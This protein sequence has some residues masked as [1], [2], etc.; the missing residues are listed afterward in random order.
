MLTLVI[1]ITKVTIRMASASP[2]AQALIERWRSEEDMNE[3]DNLLK[4]MQ[5][6][7]IF[8][9]AHQDQWEA[10]GGV[11]PDISDPNFLPKLLRK[12]EFQESKQK[13]VKQSLETGE[14]KCRSSEDFQLSSV[15]RFVSRILSPRTPYNSF[16]LY[17]GVGVGKTCAAI[18]VCESYLEAYPGRKIYIIAPPNIQEGFRRTIFDKEGLTIPKKGRNSHRGCTGDIYL[19]LTN[20][21]D[22]KDEKVIES[23]VARL[24]KSRYEFF[25][26]T[27]FY[28]HIRRLLNKIPTNLPA[29]RLE[30]LKREI[31]RNE[32]SNRAIIID[33]A[34]N[35]RDILSSTS[36][37]R[38]SQEQ[39]QGQGQGQ[40]GQGQEGQEEGQE[41]DSIDDIS[42][43]DTAESK[44]GKRLTPYLKEV[45]QISEGITLLLMTA[46]P[47]YN[48]YTEIVFLLNLL[49]IN[50]KFPTLDIDDIFDQKRQAFNREKNG[51]KLLGKVASCYVSFMRGENPLTFPLRLDPLDEKITEWPHKYP[52]GKDISEEERGR[53]VK[54]P[55]VGAS[56]TADTDTLYK[57]KVD[58]IV[59][60]S[61]GLGIASTDLLIQSGNWI[62][63]SVSEDED[64][65]SRVRQDGFDNTFEREKR[66]SVVQFRAKEDIGIE[67]LF[68]ENLPSASAKCAALVKL[69]KEAK[70]VVFVYSRFVPSGA[71]SIALALEANGYT[72][73][74]RSQL[75]ANDHR[76]PNGLQCALCERS[77]KG[78]GSVPED[79]EKG[80]EPH[81]FKPA[82]YV[83]LTGSEEI[84]PDNSKAI[85]ASRSTTN[86]Y[87]NEVKVIIGSQ[88]AGEGLD[89]RY[90]RNIVVFDSWYHLNKLE[91]IVGRGIR[92]CSHAALP[93][94]KRNCTIT[95]LVNKYLTEEDTESIDMYSYRT[96]LRKAIIVGN[97]TR[98][99]KENA[100]DC[101]LN[102]DAILVTGLD[103][104]PLLFDSQGNKRTNV[105]RND[106]PLTPL[107]D[108]L[109]TC[110]YSCYFNSEK[111][112]AEFELDKQDTSTYDEYTAR[113]QMNTL[114]RYIE[115]LFGVEEQMFLTFDSLAQH[116]NTIPRPLLISLL[117][118]MV[119]QKEFRL[120]LD[121]FRTG[122]LIHR[123]GLYVFQP[124]SIKDTSIPIAIRV[125]KIPI[126]RDDYVPKFIEKERKE[127]IDVSKILGEAVSKK[128][129]I[130]NEDSE[131]L[132][133]NVLE[134]AEEIRSGTAEKTPPLELL[135]HISTLSESEGNFKAQQE[136][137]EM[138]VWIYTNIMGD[139]D[140][141]DKFAECVIDFFWDEFITHGTKKELINLDAK[142]DA[143]S[144]T[145]EHLKWEL[146]G[147]TYIRLINYQNIIE[148][149]VIKDGKL[150]ETSKAVSEVLARASE[151]DPILL[152]PVID[153]ISTGFEYG[154]IIFNPKKS[155]FIF[156][157]VAPPSA[158]AS[159]AAKVGE[160]P[161]LG[162]GLECA[163]NSR[164][165]HPMTLL[166]KIGKEL[167]EAGKNDLGFNEDTL[168]KRRI[169]NSIRICT[170][171][172]LALRY[173]DKLEIK[174]KR[175]FYRPLEAKLRGHP[176]R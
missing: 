143:I 121:E 114:R 69:I 18:T 146:D 4:Q 11:Y 103:P 75:L 132:W 116:F 172:D 149:F 81:T 139:K 73:A 2:E 48:S 126:K 51:R 167:K 34:H 102:R 29:E 176:L 168:A 37:S 68:E 20:T 64:I 129:T 39:G 134:W 113:Y 6:A 123:N 157:I 7:N 89:L 55:C 71:L 128:I 173:M 101:T 99:L 38:K 109:D 31:I 170:V 97:V 110:D 138:I 16:L 117:E 58:E 127:S 161:R 93:E 62:F 107:C 56:F 35:L 95:L 60:T 164:T 25:G 84:S 42:P 105:N 169:Q 40:E 150:E 66:G 90:V 115:N 124:D 36:L 112:N 135:N 142:E 152:K 88:I 174:K 14:D 45:L 108:W 27:S 21:Y 141:R 17:H 41:E 162:R 158:S 13:S 175:W 125:A 70:G 156:K 50:D 53:I 151:D 67:W 111:I 28:N 57:K 133:Y 83:L 98:V 106:V 87:G 154:F 19:S 80:V 30:T 43:E 86:M 47:M 171:C 3:R 120:N 144:K 65:L 15:Q 131:Q 32:F 160:Q 46:T 100:M 148:Y 153:K 63:P 91:Q 33:E 92:N 72:N 137:V 85:T 77:E 52:N 9:S 54:L 140:A 61:E 122:R 96:A 136:R 118:E 59:S 12:R 22:E 165:E 23:K 74:T 5:E 94:S 8:P 130:G 76:R 104:I 163:N 159:S 166:L 49:L 82:K 79:A 78:H 10:D 44:G 26:Y 147:D 155:K 145:I 24:I 1:K 119:E